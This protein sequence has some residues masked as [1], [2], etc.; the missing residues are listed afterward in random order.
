V[1]LKAIPDPGPV[2]RSRH[3]CRYRK[4]S[5]GQGR[6]TRC[7]YRP[8]PNECS[9]ALDSPWR[10]DRFGTEGSPRGPSRET[11]EVGSSVRSIV[12]PPHR[13]ERD[14]AEWMQRGRFAAARRQFVIFCY[15]RW[16]TSGNALEPTK[17]GEPKASRPCWRDR[18]C[19]PR[20]N[21]VQDYPVERSEPPRRRSG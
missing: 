15:E 9:S 18:H 16:R 20:S 11:Q 14:T 10:R 1:T 2:H 17:G 3:Y 8:E 7:H 5:K 4:W 12:E 21:R 13:L 6:L 19:P